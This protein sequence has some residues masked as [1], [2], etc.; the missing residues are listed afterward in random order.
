M[1]AIYAH[2]YFGKE[3]Y[4]H[5]DSSIKDVVKKYHYAYVQGL[6]GPDTLLYHMPYKTDKINTMGDVIHKEPCSKFL[7]KAMQVVRTYGIDS[8]QYAYLIGFICH[9]AFDSEVHPY[10]DAYAERNDITHVYLET[11]F[12]KYVLLQEGLDPLAFDIYKCVMN[13]KDCAIA[14]APFYPCLNTTKA[15]L[16]LQEMAMERKLL[17]TPKAFKYTTMHTIFSLHSSF[18]GFSDMVIKNEDDIKCKES[19]LYLYKKM[20]KSIPV[21][22]DLITKLDDT[23]QNGTKL[24]K[25]FYRDFETEKK[26]YEN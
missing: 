18:K 20:I 24:D 26:Y 19:N 16:I 22:L 8:P 15:F 17:Y 2:Y 10:V 3:I 7:K 11:A 13:T 12:D 5:L 4:R 23:I 6:Q 25:R 21:A 1:P 9:F 14:M